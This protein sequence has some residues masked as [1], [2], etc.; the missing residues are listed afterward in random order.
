M[1]RF[2]KY[3]NFLEKFFLIYTQSTFIKLNNHENNFIKNILRII[4]YNI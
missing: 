2:N 1:E 4:I 3:M